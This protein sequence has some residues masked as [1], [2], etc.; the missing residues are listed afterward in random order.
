[1]RL[2]SQRV[3]VRLH[4]HCLEIWHGGQ[5]V[6]D[7]ERLPGRYGERLILDHYLELL[8]IKPEALPRARAWHQ[9]QAAGTWPTLYGRLWAELKHRHGETEGTRQ[10]LAVLWLHRAHSAEAVQAAVAQALEL[11]CCE[12]SAIA[13]LLRNQR[14]P[15]TAVPV[16]TDL[17]GLAGYGQARPVGLYAY[18]ALRPSRRVEVTRV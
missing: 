9:A 16:L 7:H 12:A 18:D 14:Q 11:G 4:A 2:V 3:E 1:M 5:V 15:A 17:G 8:H 13:L 10:V 6:A